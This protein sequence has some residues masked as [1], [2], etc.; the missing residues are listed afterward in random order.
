VTFEFSVSQD[1]DY[2]NEEYKWAEQE[3][4]ENRLE[5]I[6]G[7]ALDPNRPQPPLLDRWQV[8]LPHQCDEWLITNR[9]ENHDSAVRQLEQFVQEAQEALDALRGRRTIRDEP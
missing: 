6:R 7:V 8:S 1:R 4:I 3:F 5:G 2:Q 9:Y